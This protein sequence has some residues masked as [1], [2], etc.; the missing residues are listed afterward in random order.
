LAER[1]RPLSRKRIAERNGVPLGLVESIAR[2][3]G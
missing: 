2:G 3:M 1:A